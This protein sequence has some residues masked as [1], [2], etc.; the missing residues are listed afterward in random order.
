MHLRTVT[1]F[2]VRCHE[3]AR[4]ECAGNVTILSGPN[5]SGKTS[6]LETVH[7]C[8][9]ARTFVPVSDTAMIRQGA[10][11]SQLSVEAFTDLGTR[12]RAAV[13]FREG[14]RKKITTSHSDNATAKEIIGAMPVVAL[15]PDHKAITFGA[16]ADRRSFIDSLMAQS[17]K[18]VT[19]VLYEHRRLL[20][21]RNAMLANEG[22]FASDLWDVLTKAFV[23]A[24]AELVER[25]ASFLSDLQPLVTEEYA[26]VA[27]ESEQVTIRYEPDHVAFDSGS[28]ILDQ[29]SGAASQLTTAEKL[30]ARTL[31]G[32]QKDD[33]VFELNGR[34]VRDCASQGQHK[35][36]LVALKLAEARM[37][38]ERRSE[39]PIVLLDDVFSE[40]D[41]QR[42]SRV[43]ARMLDLGLQC[44]VT[45]TDGEAVFKHAV[46]NGASEVICINIPNDVR[47]DADTDVRTKA[48]A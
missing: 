7:T 41:S 14:Q 47:M 44:M 15:S 38:H 16:P 18:R 28:S 25:R 2:N 34:S 29:L 4:L 37:M 46:E 42:A 11:V 27:G 30:R 31:F 17:S 48:V 36:L 23:V 26:G 21:Q 9:L 19:D 6:L 1:A 45:T 8:A 12:Y 3:H 5:G 24:S 22:S 32:P 39:K 35:S 33:I 40:L 20:K 43:L 10:E 13:E